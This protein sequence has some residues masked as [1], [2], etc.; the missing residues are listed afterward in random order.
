MEKNFNYKDIPKVYTHCFNAECK[1]SA[2]CLRFLVANHADRE[3]PHFSVMN[4]AYVAGQEECAYF[5][6]ARKARL[7]LGITRLFD[8]LP[9]AKAKKIKSVMYSHFG[10]SRYYRILNKHRLIKPEEQ[11]YIRKVFLMEGVDEEVEFDSY[12]EQYEWL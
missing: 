5:H 4:P 6:E 8:N 3:T 11:E 2:E 9:H 7:A 10:R 12:V 1:R